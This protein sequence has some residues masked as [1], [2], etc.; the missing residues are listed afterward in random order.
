MSAARDGSSQRAGPTSGDLAG[1]ALPLIAQAAAP[2]ELVASAGVAATEAR[3]PIGPG[4]PAFAQ[5]LGAQ[6]TT[7]VRDGVE[8]ARIQLH[9][10]E[11]GPI[12]VQIK[13]DGQAAQV[14]LAAERGDTRQA[15]DAA[16]PTLAGSLREAGLTLAGG[17]VFQQPRDSA[18]PGSEQAAAG[19]APSE[20][21]A[22]AAERVAPADVPATVARR[23]GVVDLIA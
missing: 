18:R 23:R 11:L 19:R 5:Q 22:S 3:L 10:A 16:L 13:L 7:F 15:L 14:H 2:P 1:P 12:T 8:F 21:G 17:G 9:P 6:L 20:G 4:H